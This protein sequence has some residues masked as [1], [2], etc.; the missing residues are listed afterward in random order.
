MRRLRIVPDH[1]QRKIGFD[2]RAQIEIAAMEQRPAAVGALDAAQISSDQPFQFQIRALAPKV[3]QQ[4][5]FRRNGRVSFELEAPMSLGLL[6]RREGFGRGTDV[7]FE[8]AE[9]WRMVRG[10]VHLEPLAALRICGI[11]E[12][13]SMM[14]DAA[15]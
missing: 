13:I 7:V 3:A 1:L 2:A 15:L 9:R 4:H 10:N 6:A 14:S 11:S 8:S 5:V 12:G